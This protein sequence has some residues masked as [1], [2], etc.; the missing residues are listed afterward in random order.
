MKK[1][2]LIYSIL[3]LQKRLNQF[4]DFTTDIYAICDII[5]MITD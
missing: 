2:N 4:C 3:L 5:V 1:L